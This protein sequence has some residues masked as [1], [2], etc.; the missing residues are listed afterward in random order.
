PNTIQYTFDKGI[1]TASLN[2]LS[3]FVISSTGIA[4]FAPTAGSAVA[5]NNGTVIT[6]TFSSSAAVQGGQAAGVVNLV[7]AENGRLSGSGAVNND[8]AGFQVAPGDLTLSSL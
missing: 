8:S 5:S 1:T 6:V 2:G 3:F 4:T 7:A